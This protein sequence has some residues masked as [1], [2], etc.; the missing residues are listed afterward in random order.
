MRDDKK[1]E[2]DTGHILLLIVDSC[3]DQ[4]AMLVA[5]PT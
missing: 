2:H 3:D 5:S 1:L 4:G